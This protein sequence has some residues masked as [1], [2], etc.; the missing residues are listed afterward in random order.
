[1][2]ATRSSRDCP[3]CG[4]RAGRAHTGTYCQECGEP[5]VPERATNATHRHCYCRSK[6]V[7][8]GNMAQP[9][10]RVRYCCWCDEDRPARAAASAGQEG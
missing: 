6:T 9:T 1:M 5:L 8:T 3:H 4:S 7:D 10:K 2:P